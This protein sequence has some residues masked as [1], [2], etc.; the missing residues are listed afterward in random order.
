MQIPDRGDLVYLDFNRHTGREQ[1]GRRPVVLS[2]QSFNQTTGYASV[3]PISRTDGKWGFHVHLP[4][5][6]EVNGIVITDQVK[7]LDFLARNME[8]KGQAPEDIVNTCLKKIRTF[9]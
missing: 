8:I 5:G 1:A 7:N 4:D 9:L 2:P 3:C 6:L